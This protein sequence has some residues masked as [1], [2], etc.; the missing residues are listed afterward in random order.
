MR[1]L[2]QSGLSIERALEA[3]QRKDG[4]LTPGQLAWVLSQISIGDDAEI[5]GGGAAPELRRYLLDLI[6]R[7][8]VLA[9]P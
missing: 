7:L 8:V 9:R 1:A 4:G 2:E 5:P 3:G 6:D